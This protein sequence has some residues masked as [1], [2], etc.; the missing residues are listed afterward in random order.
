M[1]DSFQD[2]YGRCLELQKNL[3]HQYIRAYLDKKDECEEDD[4]DHGDEIGMVDGDKM[5]RH[6]EVGVKLPDIADVF[7]SAA[8]VTVPP[9]DFDGG[10]LRASMNRRE[11]SH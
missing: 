8:N 11:R 9:R 4:E 10:D 1:A 6:L 5:K 7:Q 2:A 3:V